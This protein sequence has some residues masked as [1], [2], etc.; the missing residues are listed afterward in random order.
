M[1][2]RESKHLFE[3]QDAG[4]VAVVQF[5]TAVLRDERQIRDLF[6]QLDELLTAG[7]TKVVMNF[8]GLEVFAS[9]AI[10]KLIRFNDRLRPP[11]GRLALCELTPIVEEIIDI[12]NLGKRFQI[13]PTEQSALESFV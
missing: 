3:W 11:E 9:Y 8:A 4:G 1:T 10:G 13:Y 6:E 7:H 5:R 12:M 2:K